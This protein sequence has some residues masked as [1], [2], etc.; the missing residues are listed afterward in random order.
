MWNN[1]LTLFGQCI[2]KSKVVLV[3]IRDFDADIQRIHGV[4]K[5]VLS[6]YGANRYASGRY[7]TACLEIA[8]DEA[9]QVRNHL[10][11][12]VKFNRR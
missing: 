7:G 8:N 5:L 10:D 4:V 12:R 6:A 2:I 3:I 1:C 9:S 11:A